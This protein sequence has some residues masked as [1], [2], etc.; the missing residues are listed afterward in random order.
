MNNRQRAL[1]LSNSRCFYCGEKL[2]DNYVLDHM[3]PRSKGGKAGLNLVASCVDCNAFKSDL[4]IEEFRHKLENMMIDDFHGRM[5]CKYFGVKR[6][7]FQFYFE[8]ENLLREIT[9]DERS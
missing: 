9:G 7:H 5:L 2:S 6:K 1:Q 4:S 3:I 8:K